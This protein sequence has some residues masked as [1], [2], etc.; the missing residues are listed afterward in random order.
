[1][2]GKSKSSTKTEQTQQQ[3]SATTLNPQFQQIQDQ[4]LG[5]AQQATA[6]FDASKITTGA[7]NYA[8][9]A[10]KTISGGFL[11]PAN[12][13]TLKGYVDAAINP[14]RE[15]LHS[16]VLSI[17]DA[18]QQQ[19]AYGGSRQGVVEGTALR[20]FNADAIDAASKIYYNDY[21]TE[22]GYQ[23]AGGAM[24]TGASD[25]ASSALN[26]TKNLAAIASLFA[27]Y[28]ATTN[29]SGTSTGSSNT[30]SQQSMLQNIAM[31]ASAFGGIK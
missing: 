16:N 15:Q 21:A 7:N 29:A 9:L 10:N 1:M 19:G 13:P 22:R 26:P 23:N 3:T 12:N 17:G 24:L 4:I 18:A 27:P 8:D 20:G 11:D 28:N 14:L 30:V 31:L 6:G 5:Q 2:G 25:A